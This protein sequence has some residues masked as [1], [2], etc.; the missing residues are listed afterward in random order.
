MTS[1][2]LRN[3]RPRQPRRT[4]IPW[5]TEGATEYAPENFYTRATNAHDHSNTHR[6]HVPRELDAMA[7]EVIALIP[8]YRNVHDLFRDALYHRV[9]YLT[10]EMGARNPIIQ[11]WLDLEKGQAAIER[12]RVENEMHKK[13]LDEARVAIAELKAARDEGMLLVLL[14]ELEDVLDAMRDPWHSELAEVIKAA[15]K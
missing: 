3:V 4:S 9:H 5:V 1:H 15:R 12:V 7:M 11:R 2:E 10:R 6:L 14:E 8:A 13:I